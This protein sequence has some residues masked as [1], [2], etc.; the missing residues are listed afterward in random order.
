MQLIH[1]EQL[2]SKGA[3]KLEKKELNYLKSK[4]NKVCAPHIVMGKCS[5]CDCKHPKDKYSKKQW[6]K[7]EGRRCKIC[8]GFA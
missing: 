4:Y 7:K 3:N 8:T 1:S 2:T 5:Q 6:R